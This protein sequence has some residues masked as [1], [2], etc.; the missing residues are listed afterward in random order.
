[1]K[2]IWASLPD[3]VVKS[4]KKIYVLGTGQDSF[5][6]FLSTLT[7]NV[8]IS[9]FIRYEAEDTNPRISLESAFNKKIVSFED[10]EEG[11]VVLYPEALKNVSAAEEQI[12]AKGC[13]LCKLSVHKLA[14][15]LK[16]N[17]VVIYGAANRGKKTLQLLRENGANVIGF[18]DSDQSKIGTQVEGLEVLDFNKIGKDTVVVIASGFYKEIGKQIGDS[19]HRIFVDYSSI[20]GLTYYPYVMVRSEKH[21]EDLAWMCNYHFKNLLTFVINKKIIID[22][23]S[24]FGKDIIRI[25]RLMD[26]SVEYCVADADEAGVTDGI[27]IKD[28]YDLIYEDMTNKMVMVTEAEYTKEGILYPEADFLESIGFQMNHQYCLFSGMLSEAYWP[29]AKMKRNRGIAVTPVATF[30]ILHPNTSKQYPQYVVNGNPEEA[31]IRILTLGGSTTDGGFYKPIKSWPECLYHQMKEH[32]AA[33]FNGGMLSYTSTEECLKLIRDI[34]IINPDIVISFSGLNDTSRELFD[35][36]YPF[37]HSVFKHY[38][39]LSEAD[40]EVGLES[41]EAVAD[42]WL[43]MERTMKAVCELHG[44]QFMGILQ[45]LVYKKDYLCGREKYIYH[46]GLG[47]VNPHTIEEAQTIYEELLEVRNYKEFMEDDALYDF[48]TLF[49]DNKEEIFFDH[50]HVFD[51]GNEIIAEKIYKILKEKML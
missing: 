36:K 1:M 37:C 38:Y 50:C 7:E 42:L 40:M 2:D 33:V 23:Y 16:N 3:W 17:D 34:E 30:T 14:E 46:Y 13:E 11:A 35:I 41:C 28:K 51:R 43:R 15:T 5:A 39:N 48:T 27:E 26:K 29:K 31:K 12:R 45:P 44:C 25:L 19:G 21:K 8:Y 6:I 4:D 10:I 47:N 20:Y 32:S 9:A 24:D 22:G 49:Q 18:T